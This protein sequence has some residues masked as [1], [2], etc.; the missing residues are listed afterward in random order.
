MNSPDMTDL[1]VQG[2]TFATRQRLLVQPSNVKQ[3]KDQALLMVASVFA[4]ARYTDEQV[5]AQ[6]PQEQVPKLEEPQPGVQRL[7]G[8][9][10]PVALRRQLRFR[11][12]C[13]PWQNCHLRAALLRAKLLG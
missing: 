13:A 9:H 6:L 10:A 3:F 8:Q 11:V 7:E 5:R 2:R 4:L 1:N 12:P